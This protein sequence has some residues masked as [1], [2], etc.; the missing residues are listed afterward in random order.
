MLKLWPYYVEF[1][2]HITEF[3]LNIKSSILNN[4][5]RLIFLLATSVYRQGWYSDLDES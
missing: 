4:S 1:I 3:S 2:S 5:V